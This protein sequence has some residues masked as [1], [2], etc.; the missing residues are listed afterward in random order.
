[1]DSKTSERRWA[2]L[3][4]V[5]VVW[6]AGEK[7][8][9]TSDL[10]ILAIEEENHFIQSG[11]YTTIDKLT[12]GKVVVKRLEDSGYTFFYALLYRDGKANQFHFQAWK[13]N[14]CQD[15]KGLLS[16][17]IEQKGSLRTRCSLDGTFAIDTD[18]KVQ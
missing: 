7:F 16:Y 8:P 18:K 13:E 14:A 17:Y 12:D 4:A 6:M 2:V 11:E 3:L 5:L 15:G 9:A 1:M 10:N